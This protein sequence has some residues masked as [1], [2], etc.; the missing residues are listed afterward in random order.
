MF[1]SLQE[2]KK[3]VTWAKEQKIK[4]FKINDIEFEISELSFLPETEQ[5][6][7]L[8]E[9]IG[10]TLT[11]TEQLDPKEEEELLFWSTQK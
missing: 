2:V 11:D 3:F 6:N 9:A 7:T 1:K 8:K 5:A 4:S 10:D